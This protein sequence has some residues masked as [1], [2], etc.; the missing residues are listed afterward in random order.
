M[1][2][3]TTRANFS[4]RAQYSIDLN[5]TTSYV[6][7]GTQVFIGNQAV[8]HTE[9]NNGPNSAG[10]PRSYSTPN[11]RS[12]SVTG[13]LAESGS[14]SAWAFSFTFPGVPQYQNIWGASGGFTRFYPDS[15]SIGTINVSA[16]HSLLGSASASI[17][18]IKHVFRTTFDPNGGN[19]GIYSVDEDS[20]YLMFLPTPTRSGYNFLGWVSGGTN[21]GTGTYTVNATRTLQASW[22]IATPAPVFTNGV[23]NWGTLRIGQSPSDYIEATDTTSYNLISAP[24]GLSLSNSG[25]GTFLV[26][27]ITETTT[28]VTSSI[29]VRATGPGGSTDSTDSFNLRAALPQWTDTTLS[30]ARVGTSYTSGNSFSATG[31]TSWSIS[32]IPPG[33]S[34]TGTATSTV[35]ISGTPTT[36]GAYTITATPYNRDGQTASDAGNT[37]FISLVV[38]PRVPVWVTD[39]ISTTARKGESYLG[40][41]SANFVT[42]WNDGVLPTKGFSFFGTTSASGTAFADISGTPTEYGPVT[43]TITPLNSEGESPGGRTFTINVADAF[44]V[45]NKQVLTNSIAAQDEAY[46][47]S[48]SV[49]SGPTVTYSILSGSLPPGITLNS[50]TGA[51]SGTPTTP[52]TYPF[53]VRATNLS[54]ETADTQALTIT[55]EASGG[56]VQVK[57]LSGW[58]DG[59]VYVKTQSGWV[60]GTVNVKSGSGWNPSFTN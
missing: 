11:G 30:T 55:V 20:G 27:T 17:G 47:D 42:S 18:S 32:G 13:S 25:A 57:T 50:S 36:A 31:A 59:V 43:F 2:T 15:V 58:V 60:E 54:N 12:G 41:L 5:I 6:A 3:Y 14:D 34:A 46:T 52:G 44:I 45:W 8:K 1:G 49:Q 56:Y 37:E 7:G 33:L 10:S 9:V 29:T 22:Q 40:S 23:D 35:T 16:S 26:G 28:P 53:S 4:L 19:G 39:S 21:Y 38:L 24:P 51:I 48:V